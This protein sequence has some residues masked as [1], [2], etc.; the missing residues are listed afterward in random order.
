MWEISENLHRAELTVQERSEHIAEWA[1]LCKHKAKV[2]QLATPLGGQQPKEAGVRKAAHELNLSKDQVS[3]AN[4]IAAI[5]PEAKA[6]ARDAGI[7]DN[8]SK[9]LAAAIARRKEIY[10]E[11]HPEA[12]LG[13]DRKSN[14][15]NGDLTTVQP[16]RFTAATAK[17]AIQNALAEGRA[18]SSHE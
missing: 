10:E 4:K 16:E 8:Q 12:A 5:S 15:Q 7:D 3:R 13:G 17:A 9:L 14:R 2:S 11:L 18:S 1:V 6:A